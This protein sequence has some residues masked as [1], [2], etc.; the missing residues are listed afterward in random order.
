M[1]LYL[2]TVLEEKKI[3][4][5]ATLLMTL[6][7]QNST[8]SLCQSMSSNTCQAVYSCQ[9]MSS[10]TPQAVDVKVCQVAHSKQLIHVKV[11]QVTLPKQFMSKYVK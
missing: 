6:S 10:N 5:K 2:R 1:M 7:V 8:K 4:R 3:K 11:C 9:S